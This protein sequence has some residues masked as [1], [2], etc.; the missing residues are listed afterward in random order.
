MAW[1]PQPA[2]LQEILQTIHDSTD[3]QNPQVQKNITQVR[4]VFLHQNPLH[5]ALAP[6]IPQKLNQFTRAPDYIAYLAYILAALS[7]EEERVRSIAGYLLKNNSRL[8]MQT[9][10][11]VA[12]FT[13]ASVLHVS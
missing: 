6:L 7:Q 9:S 10:L 1:A 11:Q 3:S 8:V 2:G 12:E 4:F 5:L 13:M